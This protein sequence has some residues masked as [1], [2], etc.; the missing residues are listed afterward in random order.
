MLFHCSI[1]CH[2][3]SGSV[4]RNWL[5][6]TKPFM[7]SA[8][9]IYMTSSLPIFFAMKTLLKSPGT[10]AGANQQI[11]KTNNCSYLCFLHCGS[12]CVE[13]FAW[14]GQV[15]SP[16]WLSG[17]YAKQNYSRGFFCVGNRDTQIKWFY[18]LAWINNQRL[19]SIMHIISVRLNGL[20]NT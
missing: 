14:E 5:T 2:G 4:F 10:S 12:C 3:L 17:N 9:F 15:G 6:P 20:M 11:G 19:W 8:P 13:G 16:S 1:A 7:A 18:K